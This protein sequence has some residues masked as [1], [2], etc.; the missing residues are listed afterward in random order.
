MEWD[1]EQLEPSSAAIAERLKTALPGVE[2]LFLVTDGV[3]RVEWPSENPSVEEKLVLDCADE[4]SLYWF[5]GYM[6]DFPLGVHGSIEERAEHVVSFLTKFF[7]EE[8]GCGVAI[9]DGKV[10]GGGPVWFKRYEEY[11]ATGKSDKPWWW[12]PGTAVRS[13]RGTRDQDW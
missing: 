7:D 3:L 11:V 4:V 8:V 5:R 12:E 2:A 13:W 6:Y 9:K 10:M 1:S